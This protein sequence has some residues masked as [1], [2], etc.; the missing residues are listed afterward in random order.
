MNVETLPPKRANHPSLSLP[1]PIHHRCRASLRFPNVLRIPSNNFL[2]KIAEY[3]RKKNRFYQLTFCIFCQLK[4]YFNY[5]VLQCAGW[6]KCAFRLTAMRWFSYSLFASHASVS[7]TFGIRPFVKIIHVSLVRLHYVSN[8]MKTLI[9]LNKGAVWIA[10]TENRR[11]RIVL[12]HC[13]V[14]VYL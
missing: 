13:K 1:A 11:L 8:C 14:C 10:T 2:N 12:Y 7:E 9:L 6:S 5:V 4:K 3:C